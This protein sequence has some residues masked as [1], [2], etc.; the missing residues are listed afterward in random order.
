MKYDHIKVTRARMIIGLTQAQLA[1]R[2]RKSP[3]MISQF[4]AGDIQPLPP[5]MK[6][7]AKVLGLKMED[8]I[9]EEGN[10]KRK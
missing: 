9:I 2:I 6:K 3:G 5:T 10:G 7:I 8:L 4:E 1:K